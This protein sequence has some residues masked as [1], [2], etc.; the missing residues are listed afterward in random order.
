MCGMMEVGR[1]LDRGTRKGRGRNERRARVP[2]LRE[3]M[4]PWGQVWLKQ[5]ET[6]RGS[7]KQQ[8]GR[9]RAEGLGPVA[10]LEV[11]SD[12]GDRGQATWPSSRE[13]GRERRVRQREAEADTGP[14]L[15]AG[16][17]RRDGGLVRSVP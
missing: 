6:L 14:P 17:P 2:R 12:C 5:R 11:M 9:E 15:R 8:E 3:E 13:G 7:H 4:V 16:T 10:R 1:K